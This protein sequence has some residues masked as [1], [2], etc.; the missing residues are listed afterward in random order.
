[1]ETPM[2]PPRTFTSPA[3]VTLCLLS[4]A[5]LG[6]AQSPQTQSR[7]NSAEM[8]FSFTYAGKTSASFL[9]SWQRAEGVKDLPGGRRVRTVTYTDKQTGLE[10]TA[11]TTYF[12]DR[13]AVEWL[14]RMRNRGDRDTPL[15]EQILPVDLRIPANAAEPMIFHYVLGSAL[16][17]VGPPPAPAAAGKHDA[18]PCPDCAGA[19]TGEGLAGDFAP[20][21]KRFESGGHVDFSHYVFQNG[22]H[23]ESYLPFF[24]LQWQGGGL[25]GAVGWTG[26]WKVNATRS[27]QAVTLQ[28][29]QEKTHF[30]LHPGESVR[31]PRVLLV[32]WH[33]SDWLDGQNEFRRL[34]VAHYLPKVNGQI[35]MPPIAHTGAYV[36]IFDD[37]AKKT[38]RNPLEI[39]PTLRQV[40]LGGKGGRGFADPGAALNY[41]T[42]QNQLAL[43]RGMPDVDIEA[44]WLDAG[45][46]Q[47]SW[48]GGRGSWIPNSNFPDGLRPLGDAAHKRG[49]K[50][51][52]WFD[53]EGVAPGS[54]IEKEH[55]QWVLHRPEEGSWGGIFR[56]SDPAAVH[57]M[58]DMLARHISDWGVDIFRN[59]RN[60][61][62]LPFWT[63]ADAPDRQGI[64]EIHQIEGF[65]QLWD[66]LLEKFPQLEI[67]NANWR[68]TGPDL[69]VMKRSI[70]SL[71]RSEITSGGLPHP[72]ADQAQTAELSLW[73]PLDA[74]ILNAAGPYQFRSTVTTG[75]AIGLDLQ[76]PYIDVGE[77]RNAISETKALRPFWLGDYFPLTP[78]DQDPRSWCAWQFYRPDLK[79]G[80]AMFFRRPQS[81]KAT[82][83]AGLHAL[84][85][86]MN[87][88]VTLAP[89]HD[90]SAKKILRG[91]DLA[92]LEISIPA[93]GQSLLLRYRESETH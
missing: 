79:S 40:D 73:I 90:E 70:G 54:L 7:L 84:K 23:R 12:P 66:G 38:G 55:P 41:V 19:G 20:I 50:F 78:I 1:M 30:R 74:N 52:L 85:P 8:P 69:E 77:L 51:L 49:M 45:W 39:L 18:F 3:H 37:I 43:I 93:P 16:R 26:Q 32:E 44:Y 82:M 59:D 47:G 89:A 31:T 34:L 67:D 68:V 60:T 24:N 88:E 83:Q 64:T 25:I 21:D 92:H 22:Q 86:Q 62:P 2:K 35:A 28:A 63:L 76:S 58:T 6:A 4:T 15:I 9:K 13:N 56:F 10:V 75:V 87:Y 72:I 65:Y 11:E 57:W 17:A 27:G 53:P 46:F 42:E 80:Y 71:T 91:A 33:G 61:N 81:S 29:G 48:P 14:L 5:L 36:L